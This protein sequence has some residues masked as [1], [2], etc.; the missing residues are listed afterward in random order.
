M[1]EATGELNITVITVI[2]IAAI[3]ALFY[4]FVWPAIETSLRNNTCSSLGQDW[5]A[6]KVN[7]GAASAAGNNTTYVCCPPGVTT[8]NEKCAQP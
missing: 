8:A 4:A 1:K 7:E 5:H 6:V 3:A 2:A